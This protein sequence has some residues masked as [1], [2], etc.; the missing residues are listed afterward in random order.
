[1][2]HLFLKGLV[3]VGVVLAAGGWARSDEK[4]ITLDNGVHAFLQDYCVKCHGP[5]EDKGDYVLHDFFSREGKQWRVDVAD[6]ENIYVLQDVLDQLNLGEMPPDKK[7]VKQPGSE[8][9]RA[10]ASWLTETLLSLEEDN[11]SN[12]TVLRRL[13]RAEYRNTMR[14]LLG[15]DQLTKD[16]TANF[17]ADDEYHGF[18]NIGEV[19][20]LSDAHLDAY[21]ASH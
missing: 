20:N 17:P 12:V 4:W 3:V 2:K 6:I 15:L 1:M 11:R 10:T 8:E 16:H 13:N 9:V 19:L 18:T 21:L 14:D 7:G 5:E